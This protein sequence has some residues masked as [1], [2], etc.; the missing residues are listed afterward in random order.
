MK[1][2]T[3]I[4]RTRNRSAAARF[5]TTRRCAGLKNAF[6][7]SHRAVGIAG[8]VRRARRDLSLLRRRRAMGARDASGKAMTETL[9]VPP[10]SPAADTS[11]ALE[12]VR[13]E[14]ERVRFERWMRRER[15][16]FLSLGLFGASLSS[17]AYGH[18]WSALGG[19]LVACSLLALLDD[20]AV[21]QCVTRARALWFTHG[22]HLQGREDEA[23]SKTGR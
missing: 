1:T 11:R 12:L 22:K 6:R 20:S 14:L 18:T 4:L 10:A 8:G 17:G 13:K 5:P 16:A 3:R 23:R 2:G 15:C 21:A 9:L 7:G 19:V